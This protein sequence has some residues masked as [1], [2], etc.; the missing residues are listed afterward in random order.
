MSDK[1]GHWTLGIQVNRKI[2]EKTYT[3]LRLYVPKNDKKLLLERLQAEGGDEA[4]LYFDAKFH[5]AKI[6]LTPVQPQA[7]AA[8]LSPSLAQRADQIIALIV[9]QGGTTTWPTVREKLGLP[10]ESMP[11]PFLVKELRDRGLL[12][13]RNP[14]T[15]TM[16]WKLI[17]RERMNGWTNPNSKRL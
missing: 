1:E 14:K 4:K 12:T 2:G 8:T 11:D 17:D 3:S 15:S 10:P 13:I 16:T 6:I 5:G 9:K 7:Q